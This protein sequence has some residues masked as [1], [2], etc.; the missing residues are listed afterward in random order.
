MKTILIFGPHPDD[1]EM[2]MGGTVLN[3]IDHGFDVHLCDLTNGEPTPHGTVEKRL[4][5]REEATRILG[6]SNRYLLDLPNRYLFDTKQARIKAAE[7]IRKVKPEILFIP[8]ALDA[9]PDHLAA[10]QL[11]EA[12]RF[13]AKLTKTDWA[14]DPHY[15]N[16]IIYYIASH[17]RTVFKPDFIID[18]SPYME[19]KLKIIDA[20]KSQFLENGKDAYAKQKL[21]SI[22]KYYGGLIGTQ[23]GEGFLMK[24]IPG[25]KSITEFI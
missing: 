23:F 10:S 22:A 8:Q 15:P 21:S 12:A 14:G 7:I 3:L 25:L 5:E 17:L 6:I 9:H 2:G 11:C 20:Y 16:R 19:K 24:E 4:K 13:Y 1:I 18:I